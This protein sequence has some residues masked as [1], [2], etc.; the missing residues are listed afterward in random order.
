[1]A[2][3][4]DD[5]ANDLYAGAGGA[6][7]DLPDNLDFG[8]DAED[9]PD[10]EDAATSENDDEAAD[11]AGDADGSPDAD[12][13]P[14]DGADDGTADPAD[15]ADDTGADAAD[16]DDKAAEGDEEPAPAAEKRADKEPLIPKSRFDQALRKGRVSEEANADLRRQLAELQASH[17]AASAPKVPTSEEIQSK[18]AAANEA[19]IAGDTAAAAALQAEVFASLLP[20]PAAAAEAPDARDPVDELEQ[21]ME[22]KTVLGEAYARYPELDEGHELFDED[23]AQESVDLQQTYMRRG[24]TP[25]QATQ[26]AAESVAK[27]YDLA[28][29]KVVVAPKPAPVASPASK[30]LA[31]KTKAKVEKALRAPPPLAGKATADGSENLDPNKMS[32]AEFMA[33]PESVQDRLLG[34]KM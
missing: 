28:D 4:H 32:E 23:L 8:D 2:L 5:S 16:P 17:A 15:G 31:G 14:S 13:A 25:A 6:V 20:Q 11:T 12:A 34:N 10:D 7:A 27:L 22:F 29:R 24:Y 18:M 26:K 33:L 21:R 3:E 19:L 1:M 30:A 9:M